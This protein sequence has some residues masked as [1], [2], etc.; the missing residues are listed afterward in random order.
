MFNNLSIKMRLVGTMLFM[1]VMLIVGGA[2]GVIGLQNTNNALKDVYSNQLASSIAIN[3]SMTR[4]FQ[5]RSAIDRVVL[6]PDAPTVGDLIARAAM[7]RGQSDAAWKDY[8]CLLYTS[9]SPRD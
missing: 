6:K 2:M 5:A 1:G 7:L 3:L 9:P 4:M 8:Y